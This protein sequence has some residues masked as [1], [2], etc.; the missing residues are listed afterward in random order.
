MKIIWIVVVSWLKKIMFN[1]G[2][3]IAGNQGFPARPFLF[4]CVKY[5]EKYVKRLF[6][7]I[8]IIQNKD[9]KGRGRSGKQ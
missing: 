1:C 6:I 3:P 5:F 7:N 2:K 8:I 9:K 4:Y